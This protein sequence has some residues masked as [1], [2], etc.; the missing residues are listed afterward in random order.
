LGTYIYHLTTKSRRIAVDGA[1]KDFYLLKYAR[2]D[3]F[4]KDRYSRLCDARAAKLEYAWA[5]RDFPEY[6]VQGEFEDGAVVY[7]NW[8][9]HVNSDTGKP[10]SPC[11]EIVETPSSALLAGFLR[12]H[13]KRLRFEKWHTIER[14]FPDLD[15]LRQTQAE[16]R[17][18]M[19]SR[20][21]WMSY[22]QVRKS[23]DMSELLTVQYRDEN[24]GVLLK[25]V[26]A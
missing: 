9:G 11:V 13:G 2:K 24:D 12:T 3:S 23:S 17:A 15:T 4:Y 16:I 5:V 25:M 22:K 7:T 6:V 14:S 26:M 19:G 18:F 1:P 10:H 20:P 8:P 21:L